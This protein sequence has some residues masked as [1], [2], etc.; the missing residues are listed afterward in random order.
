MKPSCFS[1]V[2]ALCATLVFEANVDAG[3]AAA[4]E[5]RNAVM[6]SNDFEVPH[7]E[8]AAESAYLLSILGN[9]NNYEIAVKSVDA[10]VEQAKAMAVNAQAESERRD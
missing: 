4:P 2:F 6:Q 5:P 10:A 9:P 8:I 7:L 1:A 3:T